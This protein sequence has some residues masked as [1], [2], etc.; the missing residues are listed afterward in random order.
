MNARLF[1]VLLNSGDDTGAFV[2][3]R[4]DVKLCC[5]FEKLVD[6]NRTLMRKI[7]GRSHVL[8]ERFFV[9]DNGHRAT[10]QHVTRSHQYRITNPCSD[11]ARPFN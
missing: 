1:D 3:Q 5:L 7:N 9:V 8:V 11:E 6:Q 2:R 4:I 10:T